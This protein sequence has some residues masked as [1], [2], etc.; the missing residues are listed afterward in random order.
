MYGPFNSFDARVLAGDLADYLI[1]RV[2]GKKM[3]PRRLTLEKVVA[4][5]IFGHIWIDARHFRAYEVFFG[6]VA[7]PSHPDCRMDTDSFD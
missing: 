4:I 6:T 2:I 1:V 3:K 7:Q 5:A